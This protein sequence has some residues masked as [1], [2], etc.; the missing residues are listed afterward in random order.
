LDSIGIGIGIGEVSTI[1]YQNS[2]FLINLGSTAT[3]WSG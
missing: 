3:K 2:V 1:G